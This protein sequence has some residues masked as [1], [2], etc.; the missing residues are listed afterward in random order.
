M[1]Y[2]CYVCKTYRGRLINRTECPTCGESMVY[3]RSKDPNDV[4]VT[5]LLASEWQDNEGVSLTFKGG[6]Y[7][8]KTLSKSR[9]SETSFESL[10]RAWDTYFN[11]RNILFPGKPY[12]S[13]PA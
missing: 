2:Y 8:V 13:K 7:V 1:L 9:Q 10:A 4:T 11:K 5:T 3:R 12:K 6:F